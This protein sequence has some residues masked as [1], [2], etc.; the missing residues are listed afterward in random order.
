MKIIAIALAG[1]NWEIG[2]H[3]DLIWRISEDMK[4]FRKVTEGN[5]IV[6]GRRTFQSLPGLLPNRRH[7]VLTR[8]PDTF[9]DQAVE[10]RESL[11]AVIKECAGGDVSQLC[12][13]GGGE[14]YRQVIE[15]GLAHK[16]ILTRVS[17]SADEADTFFPNMDRQSSYSEVSVERL[18]DSANVHT[19]LRNDLF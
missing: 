14:V 9:F 15:S 11:G 4:L 16:V 1:L 6:M 7:F 8:N 5:P 12:V 10:V 18:T 19:Y 3:N 2:Q 17:K 13:I